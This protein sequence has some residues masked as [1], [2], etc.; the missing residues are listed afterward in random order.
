[1]GLRTEWPYPLMPSDCADALR[2]GKKIGSE[3]SLERFLITLYQFEELL[4]LPFSLL[5]FHFAF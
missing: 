1:M 4:F 2:R 3:N 5:A